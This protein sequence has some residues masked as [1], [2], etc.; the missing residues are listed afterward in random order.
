[1]CVCVCL[2]TL[3]QFQ[4][5]LID[6]CTWIEGVIAWNLK[7]PVWFCQSSDPNT[8]FENGEDPIE[9]ESR[10]LEELPD[11]QLASTEASLDPGTNRW[12]L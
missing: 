11:E 7:S 5:S 9:I 8:L 1:M 12:L 3:L 2:G 10:I 4:D 6:T